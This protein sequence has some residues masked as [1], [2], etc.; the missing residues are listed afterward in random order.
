MSSPMEKLEKALQEKMD[1]EIKA[2][3][4]QAEV[5]DSEI[6]AALKAAVA[7]AS[8]DFDFGDLD[9]GDLDL[10]EDEATES[11]G[12]EGGGTISLDVVGAMRGEVP[13]D[14]DT[15]A[16]LQGYEAVFEEVD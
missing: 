1:Q 13:L 9:V 2:F 7:E 16:A 8:E 10:G 12:S 6:S 4:P 15:V 14:K 11:E 3:A 5:S